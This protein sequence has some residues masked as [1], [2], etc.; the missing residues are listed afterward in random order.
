MSGQIIICDR[1]ETNYIKPYPFITS[2][3]DIL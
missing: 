1:V 2:I 3:Y